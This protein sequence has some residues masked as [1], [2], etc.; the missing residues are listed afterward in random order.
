MP[1]GDPLVLGRQ[2]QETSRT[3]VE[4]TP[5]TNPII[6]L[7]DSAFVVKNG[8]GAGVEGYTDTRIGVRGQTATG[9]GVFGLAQELFGAATGTGVQGRSVDGPGVVGIS[10]RAG[11]VGQSAGTGVFAISGGDFTD[12]VVADALNGTAVR[13]FGGQL[14]VWGRTNDGRGVYGLA[15]ADGGVGVFG[16][17]AS[18]EASVNGIGVFGRGGTDPSVGGLAARFEGPVLI[19]G[20]LTVLGLK[21][22]AV[23]FQGSHRLVYSVESTESWFE[24]FGDGEMIDGR[25]EVRLDS[26]FA[27]LIDAE[28]YHVFLTPKADSNGLYISHQTPTGFEVREQQGGNSTLHFSYRVIGKRRDTTGSRLETVQVPPPPRSI[29]PPDDPELPTI[30]ELSESDGVKIPEEHQGPRS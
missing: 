30:P 26:D 29:V 23:P 3:V 21:S 7:D 11:V 20:N 28:H 4:R 1:D 14:G 22:A 15:Q 12:A 25:G 6:D 10:R 27:A 18:L 13:T 17:A 5:L 2:N 16:E 19:D 9:T 24:D 8:T